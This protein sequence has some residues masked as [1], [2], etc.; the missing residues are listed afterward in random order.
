MTGSVISEVRALTYVVLSKADKHVPYGELV[1]ATECITLY[2]R[3]RTNRRRYNRVQLCLY[4][5]KK[6]TAL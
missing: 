4:C 5:N 2:P 3:Y 6:I 1:N